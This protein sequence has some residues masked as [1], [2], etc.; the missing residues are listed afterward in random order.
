MDKQGIRLVFH[1][2]AKRYA[3]GVRSDVCFDDLVGM[4]HEGLLKAEKKYDVERAGFT[5]YAWWWVR[6]MIQRG[7]AEWAGYHA[8]SPGWIREL[9]YGEYSDEVSYEEG[10][11]DRAKLKKELWKKVFALPERNRGPV[12]LKYYY[13]LRD[14]DIAEVV[15]IEEREVRNALRVGI[16]MLRKQYN[17]KKIGE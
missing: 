7:L 10:D 11:G 1:V 15:G 9:R 6:K 12:F 2:A 8:N 14:K 3:A 16:K 13:G 17:D 5:V 4:G